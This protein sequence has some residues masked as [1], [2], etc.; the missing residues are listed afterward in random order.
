MLQFV[1]RIRRPDF[2]SNLKFNSPPIAALRRSI[3]SNSNSRLDNLS[4]LL[5]QRHVPP[6]WLLQIHAL[7]FTM[8]AHQDNLIAAR[9][10][11]H[12]SAE[13]AIDVFNSL[14]NPDVF[15]F[16]SLIHTMA[17]ENRPRAALL[18][19]KELKSRPISPNHLTLSFLLKACSIDAIDASSVKQIHS[20]V[21]KLGFACEAFVLNGLLVAYAKGVRDLVSA[22]HVF[23]KMPHRN[24]VCSWT[25]L[26]SSYAKLGFPDDALNLFAT[27]LTENLRPA[28]D[29]MINI[30]S[31]CSRLDLQGIQKWVNL[32]EQNAADELDSTNS[33]SF[34]YTN[35]VLVYLF[36]KWRK[37][38]KSREAFDKISENGRKSVLSWNAMIG[39]YEQNGCAVEALATFRSMISSNDCRP[40]HVTMVSILSA[41]AEIGDLSLGSWIHEYIRNGGQKST[42]ASNVNLATALI[43]M[44]SKCGDLD[45]ARAVF[46]EMSRKDVVSINAMIMGL[47]VNGNGDEALSLFSEIQEL[48]LRPNSG[49]L[50]AVL[51]ACSHSG[52][53]REGREIFN[54]MIV[55]PRLEHYACYID[56]LSRS[57][58]IEE[59]LDV[60]ASMPFEP[61][62]FVWGSLLAG[63]IRHGRLEL[64]QMISA[65]L[66]EVDPE[67]SGGY[68]M[69]SNSLAADRRWRGVVSLRGAMRE[70]GVEKQ[71]GCSWI[72]V[73]RTVH[74]FVAGSA[75]M[76]CIR[77]TLD[78]L[79]KEMRLWSS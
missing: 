67:N 72:D 19:F 47:A 69:L 22:R 76:Q 18:L 32:L 14:Q 36:G 54:D 40:N 12:Y 74:E 20:D 61:N 8:G 10:I 75:G 23:D 66:I 5:Q 6:R 73:D 57:G 13:S 9:L 29:T 1:R 2:R 71:P 65:A 28:S 46:R 53:I 41:C 7:M 56:L 4:R 16:N 58:F 3:S 37:I 35:I 44:Y 11:A 63:C 45:S 31:A 68:V 55:A 79:S 51:C 39:A 50:L 24:L 27:M 64:S 25:C 38:D 59:A 70:K 48:G 26:I 78:S 60:A 21:V 42:L 34:D 43:D 62:R 30:L 52:L 77:R 49:T 15:S 33:I 17:D